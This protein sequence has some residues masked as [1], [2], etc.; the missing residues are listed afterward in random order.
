MAD[1]Q[2]TVKRVAWDELFRFTQLFKG[3][4]ASI[5]PSKLLLGMA[6]IVLVFVGGMVL[7]TIWSIGGGTAQPGEIVAYS[8]QPAD[9]FDRNKER[10]E[11]QK[12]DNAI[13]LLGEVESER[14]TL[15]TYQRELNKINPY[16]G[17][18]F[19]DKLKK[20]AE[21]KVSS[22][23][24]DKD[25][26]SKKI[27]D[28]KKED[29]ESWSTVLGLVE[30]ELGKTED[31]IEDLLDDIDDD[32][33]DLIE[34]ALKDDAEE[35]ALAQLDDDLERAHREISSLAMQ[36]QTEMQNI[37]GVPIFDTFITHEKE[38]LYNAIMAARHLNFTGGLADYNA[39]AQAKENRQN[40]AMNTNV[41]AG[42]RDTPE[43]YRPGADCRGVVYYMLVA[44]DGV[45]WLVSEHWVYATILLVWSLLVASLFGGAI[46]RISAV[47]FARGEKISGFQAL[48]F[49]MGQL[50]SFFMAPLIPLLVIVGAG[51]LMMLGGLLGSVPVVGTLLMAILFIVAILIGL[52]AAFM[53]IGLLAGAPLMYPVIAAEGSDSFDAISRSY[54]YIFSRPFQAAFYAAVALIYGAI[55]YLF[56][57][58]FAYLALSATHAF[59]KIGLIG[60]GDRM[61][62]NADTLDVLWQKPTFWNLHQFNSAASSG[63]ESI[64]ATI[65]AIWVYLV[66]AG[67]AAYLITYF[68]NAT[69]TIYFLLRQD[70]DATDL[71][72]I[73]VEE[74]PEP[75]VVAATPEPAEEPAEEEPKEQSAD[76]PKEE[77]KTEE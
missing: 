45:C 18:A 70:V 41:P 66:I 56:V 62:P 26:K 59:V 24:W 52:G 43:L 15:A 53:T 5:Q 7:D 27:K 25:R 50:P 74:E 35:K 17:Q 51:G 9:Q 49:S 23:D 14:R 54:A 75:E 1:D 39:V 36:C 21:T 38:C 12:I 63:W 22:A 13:K 46:Y 28:Q 71:D 19:G 40:P 47:Q 67:V 69:T 8:T 32:A 2:G 6:A 4:K 33:E 58:F 68:V 48:R 77:E 30:D 61:G 16:L 55:T 3:F 65:L 20:H 42:L 72:D 37:R 31:K 73:Y 76:E 44:A 29:Q 34:K 11:E 57:R 60:G 10:W 64:C